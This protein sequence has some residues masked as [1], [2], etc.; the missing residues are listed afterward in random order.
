MKRDKFRV[1]LSGDFLKKDGSP[2]FPVFDIKPLTDKSDLEMQYLNSLDPILGDQLEDF[3]ALILLGHQF[4]SKSIPRSGRLS[5][6]ARFGVGYDSVDVSCC[7]ENDIVVCITP[8]G[9]RRPVAV[10]IIALISCVFMP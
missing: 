5:V 2:V 1:A 10:S 3:D 4:T 8:D 7:T 6:V 9:V